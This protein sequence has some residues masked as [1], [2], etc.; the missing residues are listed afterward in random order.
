MKKIL[1]SFLLL[2]L[3]ST[4]LSAK[5][6][7]WKKG[8]TFLSFL[9]NNGI[10][11]KLY[12]NLDNE[13]KELLDEIRSGQRYFITKG[14][15][16]IPV[17]DELQIEIVDKKKLSLEP[18]PFETLKGSLHL[19]IKKSFEKELYNKTHSRGLIK[20][21]KQAYRTLNLNSMKRGD[22]IS[23]FYEQKRR[24][25]KAI[26]NPKI[27]ASHI[28]INKKSYYNYL[29][30]DGRYYDSLGKEYR[31]VKKSY[32]P[33]IRPIEHTRVSSGFTHRR[34]HPILHRYRAH[35]GID[36][37]NCTGTPIKSTAKG[38][39]IYIGWKGGYGRCIKI[40]HA[41]G[42][43]SLYAHMSRYRKGLH[44]G[45]WVSQG[46]VIGYV[47][48]S[49]RSTGPHLHFGMYKKGKAVNPAKYVRIKRDKTL[50]NKLKGKEYRDLRKRVV[51][52]RSRFKKL[53]KSGGEPLYIKK[54]NYLV[55]KK[56]R[57]IE[58]NL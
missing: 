57:D 12:Y 54:N 10:S 1:L 49:G 23:I 34:Y 18:I 56:N 52:Y 47:G 4:L 15:I 36:Y 45:S 20:S 29:A 24:E 48:S 21:L 9:R 25:G 3:L 37:A 44:V 13:D 19:V 7:H 32:I 42:L 31:V 55:M 35:L 8:T 38:K 2:T 17:T 30:K 53:R 26:E 22:K 16:V 39:I 28:T 43:V 51:K 6:Y 27:L 33:Y 41:N 46:K 5:T 58:V 14:K 40:E 11:Q 50:V